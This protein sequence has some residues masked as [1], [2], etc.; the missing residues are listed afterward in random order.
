MFFDKDDKFCLKFNEKVI[1]KVGIEFFGEVD[2][3]FFFYI[4]YFEYMFG[5]GINF[6]FIE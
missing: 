4:I 2:C 1:W 6:L 5:E 3:F